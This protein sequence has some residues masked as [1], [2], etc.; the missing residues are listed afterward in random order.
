MAAEGRR[1]SAVIE[2]LVQE[3]VREGQTRSHIPSSV[4][5]VSLRDPYGKRQ[6][7]LDQTASTLDCPH[8]VVCKIGKGSSGD[9]A[10]ETTAAASEI[11]DVTLS[12]ETIISPEEGLSTNLLAV[13]GG[14]GC[15]NAN[16]AV[17]EA[18]GKERCKKRWGME[19][20]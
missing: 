18:T 4:S 15:S 1:F 5:M 7:A 2:V 11:S 17:R 10:L 13:G 6:H 16:E 20:S 19:G 14:G 12:K 3:M 8:P 9:V